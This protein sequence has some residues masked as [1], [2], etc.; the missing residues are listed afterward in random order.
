M[1]KKILFLGGIILLGLLAKESLRAAKRREQD[2]KKI[3][4]FRT[5]LKIH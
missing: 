2:Q 5:A 3:D 4:A 1:F